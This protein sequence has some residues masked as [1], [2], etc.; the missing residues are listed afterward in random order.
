MRRLLKA[1]CVAAVILLA[2]VGPW[3][4][5]TICDIKAKS[6]VIRQEAISSYG[7]DEVMR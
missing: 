6:A 2:I 4:V 7:G 3:F 5:P 1:T